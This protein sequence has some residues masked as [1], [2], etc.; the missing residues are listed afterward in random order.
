MPGSESSIVLG[1]SCFVRVD[2]RL[3]TRGDAPLFPDIERSAAQAFRAIDELGWVADGN[4]MPAEEHHR[5][6]DAAT[7]WV[8]ADAVGVYGFLSAER[9][10][11]A[12]HIHEVS[13]ARAYQGLGWG[14]RLM[15]A[16]AAHA[17]SVR[18][19]AMTL[20]TFGHVPWNAPF[21]ERLGFRREDISSLDRRLADTLRAE[22]QQG[23]APGSRCAM[24]RPLR[25]R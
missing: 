25:P 21:Y 17:S 18:L 23:F 3:A 7:C 10:A 15:E 19:H 12:L 20:T 9:V 14:R 22:Y 11:D 16:A 5:F 2:V 4:P 13:V 1:T 8:V 24:V 6:I